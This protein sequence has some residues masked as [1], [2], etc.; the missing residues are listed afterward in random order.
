[1][2]DLLCL[3][4]FLTIDRQ[5]DDCR[6]DFTMIM[7]QMGSWK[8]IK[9]F[10]LCLELKHRVKLSEDTLHYF[11]IRGATNDVFL[12]IHL[13]IIFLISDSSF[14]VTRQKIWKYKP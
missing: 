2:A 9:L 8:I 13:Q 11:H 7:G 10:V 1:M 14:C 4:W 5:R 12:L 6:P 3:C